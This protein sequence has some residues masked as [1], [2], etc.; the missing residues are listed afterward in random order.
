MRLA[1][2]GNEFMKKI[3]EENTFPECFSQNDT[4]SAYTWLL[5]I[6]KELFS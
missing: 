6:S 3:H 5:I 2:D 4:E 1:E